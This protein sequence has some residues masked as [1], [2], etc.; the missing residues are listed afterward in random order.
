[1]SE[2]KPILEESVLKLYQTI[3]YINIVET[4]SRILAERTA[5]NA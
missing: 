3:D 4:V 2:D 1:M 5:K